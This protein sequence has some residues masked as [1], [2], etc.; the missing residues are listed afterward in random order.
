MRTNRK[1][2][3][4]YRGM[5]KHFVN[6][7]RIKRLELGLSQE[8]MAEALSISTTAYGDIERGKTDIT[9]SRLE[10]IAEVLKIDLK[11]LLGL[12]KNTDDS[13]TKLKIEKL[14]AENQK[15]LLENMLLRQKLVQKLVLEHIKDI[16]NSPSPR[17]RIGF[18]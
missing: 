17:P 5:R 2:F 6:T 7:L 9:L 11:V 12:S 14:E 16:E 13:I 15:L 3:V 10:Q 4:V 8:N 1:A 18:K